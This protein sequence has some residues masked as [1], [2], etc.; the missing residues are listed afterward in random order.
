MSLIHSN[1]LSRME[2]RIRRVEKMC[3]FMKGD[4]GSGDESV[5]VYDVYG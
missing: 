5:E 1:S 3:L 2:D 4:Y